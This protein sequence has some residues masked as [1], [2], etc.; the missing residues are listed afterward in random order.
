MCWR[1]PSP[2]NQG[3]LDAFANAGIPMRKRVASSILHWK[4]ALFAGQHVVEFSGANYSDNAWVPVK[5]RARI[6]S[7]NRSTSPTIRRSWTAS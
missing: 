2:F 7:T 3:V 5:A 6:T 1:L 4:I